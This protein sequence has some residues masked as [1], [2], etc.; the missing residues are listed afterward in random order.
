MPRLRYYSQTGTDFFQ[1]YYDTPRADGIYSSDFRL[2]SFGNL[3]GGL[4]L[5]RE[6]HNVSRFAENITFEAGF[7]YTAHAADLKLSGNDNLN[8]TDFDYVL[9]NST[10]NIKF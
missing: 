9:V 6:W 2:A 5:I 10:I 3:S 1:Y 4:K 8:I 7:E